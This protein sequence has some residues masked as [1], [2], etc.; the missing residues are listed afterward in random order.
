MGRVADAYDRALRRPVAIK[1][2]LTA[3]GVDLARFEREA[4]ITARL[5]HPGI[6]PIH[7]AGAPPTARRST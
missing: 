7:D 3:S 5:E 6:V 1:E 4:R 2:M